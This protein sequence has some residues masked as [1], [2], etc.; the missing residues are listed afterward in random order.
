MATSKIISHLPKKRAPISAPNVICVGKFMLICP[1]TIDKE[2]ELRNN[3][4]LLNLSHSNLGN[5]SLQLVNIILGRARYTASN[6][7]DITITH[8]AVQ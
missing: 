8:Q 2:P 4:V 5:Y 7:L 6:E 1:P 3:K